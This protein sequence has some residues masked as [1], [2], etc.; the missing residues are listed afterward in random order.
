M[1]LFFKESLIRNVELNIRIGLM[2]AGAGIVEKVRKSM[3]PGHGR[4]WKRK[5]H[6]RNDVHIAST[7]GRPPAPWSYRLHDSIMFH[8]SFGDKS[9]M[10]PNAQKTDGIGRP[11]HIY[12]EHVVSIGSNVPY[13]GTMEFGM[14]EKGI[15]PRPYLWPSLK[16]S[17]ALIKKAFDRC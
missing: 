1:F 7:P 8:T 15:K 9:D 17:R 6:V 11:W 2:E 10:G 16:K 14:K 13:A 3:V 12:G 4:R 5:G